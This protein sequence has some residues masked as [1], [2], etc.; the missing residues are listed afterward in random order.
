MELVPMKEARERANALKL[1]N[2]PLGLLFNFH[3]IMLK[4]G[5][6]RMTL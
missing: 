2:T 1:L 4:D 3:E 5:I 6:T